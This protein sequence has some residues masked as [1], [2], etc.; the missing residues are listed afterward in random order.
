[1][2][3]LRITNSTHVY[4]KDEIYELKEGD[5]AVLTENLVF[6]AP[7]GVH[8]VFRGTIVQVAEVFETSKYYRVKAG[9]AMFS[10]VPLESLRKY[11]DD[12]AVKCW[13]QTW[14]PN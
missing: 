2:A 1:M 13:Q 3:K 5:Y 9:N 8:V 12:D 6:D 11:T 7:V 10:I 4:Y 14:A